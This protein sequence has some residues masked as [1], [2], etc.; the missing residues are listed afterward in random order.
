MKRRLVAIWTMLKHLPAA[1]WKLLFLVFLIV[2]VVVIWAII[3]N[4]DST[5]GPSQPSASSVPFA[6]MTPAQHLAAATAILE[7]DNPLEI[8]KE[9]TDEAFH[10][11]NAIPDNS[12]ESKEAAKLMRHSL[13]SSKDAYFAR[14]REKY[15]SDLEKKLTHAGFDSVAT[16][17][18]DKLVLSSD[19]FN[20]EANRVHIL[21]TLRSSSNAHDLCDMGFRNLT[22]TGR[23]ILSGMHTYSLDCR[24][25]SKRTAR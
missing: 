2:S 4:S 24:D 17:S 9:K 8:P 10:H 14:V 25:Q 18:M 19:L 6:Q 7:V 1:S 11:I 12:P 23:G 20:D 21:G 22:L 3:P 16:V 15:A 13:E 5:G